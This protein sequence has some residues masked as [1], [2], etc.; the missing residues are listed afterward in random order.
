MPKDGQTSGAPT[1]QQKAGARSMV[2]LPGP[3]A[4]Y[5]PSRRSQSVFLVEAHHKR[6]AQNAEE[7]PVGENFYVGSNDYAGNSGDRNLDDK[8]GPSVWQ[9][10]DEVGN[11]GW[12]LFTENRDSLGKDRRMNLAIPEDQKWIY[13][14][15]I[16]QVSEVGLKNITDGASKTYLCGERYV[17]GGN[18]NRDNRPDSTTSSVDGSDSWG[19]SWGGCKDTL[20][21]GHSLPLQ[22]Y[23][24][25]GGGDL[26]GS[27]HPAAFHM[28][29]CDGHVEGVSYDID[30]LVHQNN[31]NRRD[32]GP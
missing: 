11:T 2:F 6:F 9:A 5:C 24:L 20:R 16:F 26:F 29:F 18:A 28:A 8:T 7:N 19:W 10:G 3:A 22:D 13:T 15:V 23:P 17:R 25:V 4:F 12:L 27:A 1:A 30:L 21:S 31:A 32:G 14:G